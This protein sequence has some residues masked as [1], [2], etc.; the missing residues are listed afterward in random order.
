VYANPDVSIG[1]DPAEYCDSEGAVLL[2]AT[3]TGGGGNYFYFWNTPTGTSGGDT[4]NA[5]AP[6]P[7][8]VTVTD[9]NGCTNT[10]VIT[11]ISHPNPY[12]EINDP[13]PICESLEFFTITAIPTGGT[14]SGDYI[15][16]TGDLNPNTIDP[17]TYSISYSYVDGNECEGTAV[18][19]Y[20]IVPVPNAFSE[21]NGPLCEGQPILLFGETDGS[22]STI[23]YLWSGPNGFTSTLQ[24]PTNATLGGFY[25]L[26]VTIDGCPSLPAVTEVLVT[27]MPDAVALNGG[28]YCNG[29]SIQL[30]GST[31]SSGNTISYQWSGPN[32]YTS[33]VQNPTDATVAGTYSLIITVDN[34]ASAVALTDVIFNAPPD[35]IATNNG[36]YCSGD[37][38][39][40]SGNTNSPG[41]TFNYSWSGP[42]GYVSNQQNPND[43]L[44]PGLYQLIV[45]VDGC[46]STATGT[47]VTINSLPQPTITGENAFCTGFSA[48]IDAGA[49]YTGYVWNDASISQTLEVFAPGTYT[50]T[51]T[52]ANGCNGQASFAVTENTSLAPVITGALAFCEGSGTTLDAGT[53]FSNYQWSTGETSQTIQVTN[54]GNYGVIVTDADGC[55]GSANITTTVNSNPNVTIGGSTTYCIGGSTILDAGAGFSTYNWSNSSTAQSIT[56]SSPGIYSVD[57]VDINGCAGSA[58][59]TITESTSLSPVITGNDAFCENGSTTLNAG[60]GFD[61]YL[62]SDGSGN[63][64][65]VVTAA[66][67]Y[68]V[69]VSDNQGCSGET[70]I[71]INE[72]LP[73]SAVVQASAQLCNTT[74][75][76]S[77]LNLYSLI[78]SGD[79]N[80]SWNDADNSGAVGL[81]NN[82]NFNNVPA[83]DYQFVYTT[84]SAIDPCPEAIYQVVVTVLDCTCPDVLFF[85]M[86]PLCNAGDILDLATIENTTESGSWSIIQTPAGSNPGSLNGSVFNTTGGDPGQYIFQFSLQNSPPPGC[87]TDFQVNVNVDQAVDA[88]I[89]AQPVSYCSNDN[90]FVSLA[91]LITGA[92]ANGTWTE[93]STTPSQGSAFNAAN[94]TFA[95][96]NQ[97][98]GVYTF[99]YDLTANGVCPD[100]AT[101]VSVIINP[102]P[103]AVVADFGILNCINTT[104]SLDAEGSSFGPGF[105]INWA[106]PGVLADGNENT[107]HPTIDEPGNY[108]LTIT[109]TLTGCSNTASV[110][111]IQNI[112]APSDALVLSQDPSCFGDQNGFITINQV[113]GGTP[114]YL[115]S[116][117]NGPFSNIDTYNNLTA[118]TY[119]LVLEDANGCRWDT[120]ITI[121]EPSG[122]TIDLGQDIELNLGESAMIQANV[123]QPSSQIDTLIWSPGNLMECFDMVCLEGIVQTFNSVTLSATVY[124]E[125]GCTDSD[126]ISITVRKIRKIFI[127]TVFSPNDDDINDVFY[128]LGDETQ[129]V[130]IKKFMIFNRWGNVLHEAVDFLPNDPAQGW[131]GRFKNEILNP[132]VFVYTAEVEYIDGLVEILTGDVTLI[133]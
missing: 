26:E 94:G 79:M 75:G 8:I 11:V 85:N 7:H 47:T 45:T 69:T 121:I 50:V 18:L 23:A 93:T 59:V 44:Q 53:G 13:G 52:D 68:S 41:N 49:G 62:W 86:N 39:E 98:P 99:E 42:N 38:I 6:G 12:V 103:I 64:M 83:G 28:P 97:L 58:S 92:D 108:I 107:L 16:P 37:T 131:D 51:V 66:G 104:Q 70:S 95:T 96:S 22:G 15:S 2:T 81:F 63:Q 25:T 101:E 4:Y 111:V 88:G 110:T 129:I 102:L 65:L 90:E 132:G 34:C 128:I 105:D 126:D 60:S 127:P 116:L 56:V 100:D 55:T 46:N 91:G 35:A 5:T 87:P 74:A 48:T 109:N 89:A 106:G 119:D 40:L 67:N 17:G 54:G 117:N 71:T 19:N 130:R 118:G 31:S 112:D 30:L 20:T 84:N 27:E 125:N 72:V 3:G 82:L 123:N 36:P 113:I 61:T 114:P 29:Q 80:G 73:P 21:N 10:S 1:P 133:R 115:F 9:V 78:L 76:G 120:S 122:I 43:A 14:F 33:D 57:V 24:N 32:G 124:D 77:I